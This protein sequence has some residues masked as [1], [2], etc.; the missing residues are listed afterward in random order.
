MRK[1]GDTCNTYFWEFLAYIVD[2]RVG[3][4]LYNVPIIRDFYNEFPKDG[5]GVPPERYVA[6]QI[7]IVLCALY[8]IAKAPYD[9]AHAASRASKQEV[10]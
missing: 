4:S 7:Y 10:H 3:G 2:T 9:L 1:L 8:M 6:F 5:M